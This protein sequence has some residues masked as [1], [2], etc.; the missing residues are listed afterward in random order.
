VVSWSVQELPAVNI[1]IKAHFSRSILVECIESI[2]QGVVHTFLFWVLLGQWR[3]GD[4]AQLLDDLFGEF[5]NVLFPSLL[6][7][8]ASLFRGLEAVVLSVDVLEA[9]SHLAKDMLQ[10]Q[11]CHSV[12]L[13]GLLEFVDVN[14]SR[15][16][17]IN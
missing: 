16:V 6:Q 7:Q 12:A 10:V 2:L 8:S 13:D 3:A 14:E 11:F 17:G 15:F 4:N 9:N 5:R 1:L